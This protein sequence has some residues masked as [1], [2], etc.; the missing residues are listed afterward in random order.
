MSMGRPALM[1]LLGIACCA[2]GYGLNSVWCIL[3]GHTPEFMASIAEAGLVVNTRLF[4]LAGVLAFALVCIALP[5]LMRRSDGVLRFALP[6][7][8]VVGTV[9]FTLPA[10]G[11]LAPMVPTAL[12]GLFLTGIVFFWVAARYI[13]LLA[14]S[15]GVRATIAAVAGGLVVKVALAEAFNGVPSFAMHLGCAIAALLLAAGLFEIACALF[16]RATTP[17]D[18]AAGVRIADEAPGRAAGNGTAGHPRRTIFGVPQREPLGAPAPRSTRIS[19]YLLLIVAGVVLAVARSVSNLGLW[20]GSGAISDTSPWLV[21]VLVPG[22]LVLLFA[23]FVLVRPSR[24]PLAARFQPALFLTM[25]GLFAVAIQSDPSGASLVLLTVVIQVSELFA[26]LTLWAVTATALGVLGMPS[27]RAVSLGWGIYAA[28]SLVWV[29][30][31]ANA[32]MIVTLIVMLALYLGTVGLLYVI[33]TLSGGRGGVGEDPS[34]APTH[35]TT[36]PFGIPGLAAAHASRGDTGGPA[37]ASHDGTQVGQP[38]DAQAALVT[39]AQP[40]IDRCQALAAIYG[41]SPRETEVL[42]LVVQ[43][44]SYAVVQE[45]LCLSGSTV[46]THM[47]HIYTKTGA[48]GRQAL[49][50]LVWRTDPTTP[51]GPR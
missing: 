9:C 49:L 33:G 32:P 40:L 41:L 21:G 13:L 36:G 12:V 16:R 2:V 29:A 48:T 20:G 42:E 45:E 1:R 37:P 25:A 38:H 43:G 15:Q 5:G 6:L 22:A 27:Y 46:K 47:S 24:L 3:M 26:H 51:S 31:L 50:D 28:A 23:H 34:D 44:R 14:R 10:N 19:M 4:Y 35:G 18:G 8:G 17:G 7:V 11:L 30:V 39:A